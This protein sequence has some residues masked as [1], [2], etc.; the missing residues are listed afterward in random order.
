MEFLEQEKNY[1]VTRDASAT[2]SQAKGNLFA[3]DNSFLIAV[4]VYFVAMVLFI[5]LR[6]VGGFGAFRLLDESVGEAASDVIVT[7]VIQI[8]I[9]LLV[10]LVLVK[11]F[12]K[13]S[14]K[15]T[16]AGIGLNRPHRRVIGWA[17]LLGVLLW[18]LNIFV[19][20]LSHMVLLL[21]G[22]RVSG[23]DSAYVGPVGLLVA[24]V[25]I[26]VLPGFCEE[27]AN[28]GVLMNGLISRLGVWR[29][30]LL[31]SLI[32]GLM[33]LNIYQTF[34]AT[35]LGVFMAL[36]VL[37]TRSLWTGIIIHFC[38]NA[39]GVIMGFA[40]KENWV[41]YQLFTKFLGL[42]DQFG[43][44]LLFLFIAGV[45]MLI[46]GIIHRFARENYKAN[47]REYF[48]AFLKKNPQYIS[49]KLSAGQAVSLEDMSR[50]VDEHTRRLGKF[51]A[52]RFYLEGQRVPQRLGAGEK[53]LLFGIIFL[54][55]VVTGMTLVWGLL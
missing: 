28:R 55:S 5:V 6:V 1:P 12:S 46:V 27:G 47:E 32:F 54:T 8:V 17:F 42:F 2:P 31:S 33:H 50:T 53:T 14:V 20:N 35:I 24:I 30:V 44:L 15:Q 16:L 18:F 4:S 40:Q 22:F 19:A 10:P 37:A 26:G 48:A 36:A 51:K 13:S 41:I 11:I 25:M 49:E 43:V 21:I 3:H 38:N 34:Y 39:I 52:I 45:Y 9:L 7:V 29:A 23:G